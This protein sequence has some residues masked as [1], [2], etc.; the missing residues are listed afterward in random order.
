MNR[1]RVAAVAA[2]VALTSGC[3]NA[4]FGGLYDA[5]LPGGADLG[6]EP[7]R[8]TA[9]FAD[10]L[11]LVPQAGVKVNDVSVG[12]VERIELGPDNSTVRVRL[13]VNGDVDLPANAHARLRQSSLLGEKFVELTRPQQ[14]QGE[15]A[16]GAVV[17][18]ERT[19]RNPQVEEVLG[20]LS[21]LLNGGGVSQLQD[22]VGE[23]NKAFDGNEA[24]I[25]SLLGNLDETVSRLD[26]QK[27]DITRAIDS[28]AGLSG[29]LREQTGQIETGLRDLEP[30]I[31]VLEEQRGGLVRML[32]SLDELSGVATGTVNASQDDLIAN[33]NA[34]EPS[35]RQL[36]NTGSELPDAI[37]F[38][39]TYPFPE[40]AMKPLK[41]D[42]VNADVRVD[43][44][45]SGLVENLTRS[46]GPLLPIAGINDAPPKD[47][48]KSRPDGES[49]PPD[50]A[51]GGP[52]EAP[53]TPEAGD[54]PNDDDQQDDDQTPGPGA[55]DD[56]WVPLP[57]RTEEPR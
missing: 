51:Q 48:P 11:D 15:L 32:Q 14:P 41:G 53:A 33:L 1:M 21:M 52:G 38:L 56:L 30:G 8:V 39:A 46:S 6:A 57:S 25:R 13:V 40:Y 43:L 27:G 18:L 24:E 19:N 35:L 47:A 9:E 5:P 3:G 45:L 31:R 42:F 16:E 44:E 55:D 28:L 17:P 2:L 10:V 54:P 34:I 12:R 26:A 49:P 20:A 7:L 50:D 29:T 37:G 36:A 4:G 23:L 22:I